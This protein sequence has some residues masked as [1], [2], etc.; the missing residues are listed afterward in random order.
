MSASA[1]QDETIWRAYCQGRSQAKL[2][3]EFNRSQQAISQAIARHRATI[4]DE[5]RDEII[6]REVALLTTIRDEVL[7]LWRTTNGVPVTAGKDGKYVIDPDTHE[8]ARDHT[9]RIAALR[10]ADMYTD[11]LARIVGTYAATRID[12]GKAEDEATNQAAAEASV[13]LH[14]GTDGDD[15]A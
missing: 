12:L 14:G 15:R 3:R 5:T 13:Y 2:A 8:V 4:T 1:D 11:R 10:A 6:K 7:E 9:G